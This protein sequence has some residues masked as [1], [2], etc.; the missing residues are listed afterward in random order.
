MNFTE[1]RKYAFQ[2]MES[3]L[4]SDL[5]YHGIHHT[6]DVCRAV[7][8]LCKDEGIIGQDLTLVRTAAVYHD[9][10]FIKQY[11]NNEPLAVKIAEEILPQFGYST[12]EI[13]LIGE[14]ILSTQ[15]PQKPKNKI[16]E[17]MCDADLDYL[18]RSDFFEISETLKK[19]WF[20]YGLVSSE[21][22]FYQKQIRFFENHQYFTSTS[23]AKRGPVK[24][25]HLLFLQQV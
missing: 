8:E 13:K 2:L 20:A 4:P 3:E 9:I 15:I 12:N 25:Q 18:G 10:G 16:E 5:Y 14:I 24:D 11:Q 7:E 1:A 21:E 23:R 22:E 17:V 6:R 19:E